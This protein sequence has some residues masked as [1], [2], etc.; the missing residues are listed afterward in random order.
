MMSGFAIVLMTLVSLYAVVHLVK[1]VKYMKPTAKSNKPCY[2]IKP[3]EGSMMSIKDS[4]YIIK[5]I[6]Y[7]IGQE[8]KNGIYNA[9]IKIDLRYASTS[10]I[11]RAIGVLESDG[12][13]VKEMGGTPT[14]LVFNIDWAKTRMVNET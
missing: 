8:S 4:G 5:R 2:E 1:Y 13:K 14:A 11:Y 12:A 7:F 9:D 10:S 3:E 6:G